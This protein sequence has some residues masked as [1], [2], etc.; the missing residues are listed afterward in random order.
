[1]KSGI[2]HPSMLVRGI[3]AEPRASA[4]VLLFGLLAPDITTG[5]MT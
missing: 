4:P 1:M 5:G 3:R 2:Y